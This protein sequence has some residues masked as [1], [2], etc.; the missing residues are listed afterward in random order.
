MTVVGY[1][2]SGK[3]S[4]LMDTCDAP[5]RRPDISR[6]FKERV[7]IL[8]LT[9]LVAPKKLPL[10]YIDLHDPTT[11]LSALLNRLRKH[12]PDDG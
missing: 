1:A 6:W 2:T 10:K 7:L 9:L 8:N 12:L 3:T 5:L 11:T 4:V